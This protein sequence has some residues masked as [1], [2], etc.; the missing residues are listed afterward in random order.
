MIKKVLV[1]TG[2]NKSRAAQLLGIDASTPWRKMKR[3]QE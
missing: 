3:Y 1:Q 2:G